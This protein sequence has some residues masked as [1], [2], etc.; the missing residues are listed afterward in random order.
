MSNK[1][2]N[3]DNSFV[4]PAIFHINDSVNDKINESFQKFMDEHRYRKEPTPEVEVVINTS[5][6]QLYAMSAIISRIVEL[7]EEGITMVNTTVRGRANSAGFYIFIVGYKRRVCDLSTVMFHEGR[8][9][10]PPGTPYEEV[11]DLYNTSIVRH[12]KYLDLVWKHTCI[13]KKLIR[14][15]IKEKRDLLFDKDKMM[16]LLREVKW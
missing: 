15:A 14:K 16:S 13:P 8:M 2:E 10:V 1:F 7:N 12:E 6:G 5:G 11:S 4:K 3:N 9:G